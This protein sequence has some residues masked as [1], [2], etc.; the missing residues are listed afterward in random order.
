MCTGAPGRRS[1]AGAAAGGARGRLAATERGKAGS[2]W[3]RGTP[4]VAA[5]LVH[6]HLHHLVLGL[7][8]L[9]HIHE[10]AGLPMAHHQ[11]VNGLTGVFA[12]VCMCVWMCACV[13][14]YLCGE[15]VHV[16]CTNEVK[17]TGLPSNGIADMLGMEFD[18]SKR[19][20]R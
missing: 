2:Q 6:L 7:L 4:V 20:T 19:R 15:R 8:T 11:G 5:A 18:M 16:C 17:A 14:A 9:H 3:K 12:N 1:A 10:Q 13:R